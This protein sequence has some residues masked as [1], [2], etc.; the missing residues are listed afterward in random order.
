MHGGIHA[1]NAFIPKP[2]L[3]PSPNTD[4]NE[5]LFWTGELRGHYRDWNL[6]ESQKFEFD[7]N[8]SSTPHQ[9]ALDVVIARRPD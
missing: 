5:S 6:I 2:H 8:F 4:P 1:T 3:D 9:H 7:C